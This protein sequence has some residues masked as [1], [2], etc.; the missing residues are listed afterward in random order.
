MFRIDVIEV[1]YFDV[2]I[3]NIRYQKLIC[4]GR[5]YSI[6][7]RKHEDAGIILHMYAFFDGQK[8]DF[9]IVTNTNYS[10]VE[11]PTEDEIIEYQLRHG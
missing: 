2:T 1:T 5:I 8:R 6:D 9:A 3:D 11:Y 4:I 7:N 10:H